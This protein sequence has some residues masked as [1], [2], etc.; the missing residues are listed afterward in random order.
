VLR[1]VDRA[2]HK[3]RQAPPGVRLTGKALGRD[4]HMPITQ[5]YRR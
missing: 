4:R 2:E 1:L 5:R 3:R